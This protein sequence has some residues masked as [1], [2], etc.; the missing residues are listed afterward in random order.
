MEYENRIRQYST[1]DKVFR[2]FATLQVAHPSGES[3]EVFMTP[4]DFL[5]SMTPGIKQPDGNRTHIVYMCNMIHLSILF[6]FY[7]F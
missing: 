7:C 4:D 6:I 1:P 3:H 2:Y 5:R